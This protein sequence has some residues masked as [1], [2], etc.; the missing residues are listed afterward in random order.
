MLSFQQQFDT[1]HIFNIHIGRTHYVRIKT[2]PC[3][4]FWRH[5]FPKRWQKTKLLAGD[6]TKGIIELIKEPRQEEDQGEK[7]NS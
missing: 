4:S 2:F 5:L 1:K 6:N 7:N 3:E